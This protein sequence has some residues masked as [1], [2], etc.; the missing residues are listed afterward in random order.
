MVHAGDF[1]SQG[2]YPE[3]EDFI[4]WFDS[5]PFKH[6]VFIAGN[7]DG[8]LEAM[9]GSESEFMRALVKTGRIKGEGLHYLRDSSVVIEGKVFYG[10]PWQPVFCDWA[11]QRKRGAEMAEK[12]KLIPEK[13]DIL[14]THGPPYGHG[15]QAPP[16]FSK[17]KRNVG[18]MELLKRVIEV[19]PQLHI[20]G[21][22]HCGY[23]LTDSDEAPKTVFAN[24]STCT[25]QY[26]PDN[27]P[28][29]L[30]L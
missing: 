14:I 15:D 5:Q 21:H 13:V 8:C 24:V 2:N 9:Q 12:W 23:G 25:E 28:M 10:A 29:I 26:S 17:F 22:I 19:G 1:C 27:P 11:F 20:F 7:H 4:K 6:K 18:C 16:Y 30:D 3:F